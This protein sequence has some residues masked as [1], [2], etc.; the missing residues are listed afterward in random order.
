MTT[1]RIFS[2]EN[3]PDIK[4][5]IKSV[6]NKKNLNDLYLKFDQKKNK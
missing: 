4:R 3:N 5:R 1:T 2:R 6:K